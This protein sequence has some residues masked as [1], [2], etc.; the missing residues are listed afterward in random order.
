MDQSTYGAPQVWTAPS[1]EGL[2][3]A[4]AE[5]ASGEPSRSERE[6]TAP[7]AKPVGISLAESKIGSWFSTNT[8]DAI[9]VI[10][11]SVFN[12]ITLVL[13]ATS[14][15]TFRTVRGH[16]NQQHSAGRVGRRQAINRRAAER[17]GA[18]EV[19][20]EDNMDRLHR[21]GDM[22]KIPSHLIPRYRFRHARRGLY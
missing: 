7:D 16:L 11:L 13:L 10:T 14:Y 6:D 9:I 8:I 19:F 3:M 1:A 2:S 20:S 5:G 18:P 4:A 12:L 15:R 22:P 21:L 17:L